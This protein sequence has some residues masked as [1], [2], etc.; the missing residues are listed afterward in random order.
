MAIT[1]DLVEHGEPFVERAIDEVVAVGVKHVEEERIERSARAAVGVAVAS[2]RAHRV[3]K[4]VR[5][6]L[7]VDAD[8]FSVEH[9]RVHRQ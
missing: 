7:V 8:R 6:C 3:L 2:E 9:H 5:S 4:G 1:D